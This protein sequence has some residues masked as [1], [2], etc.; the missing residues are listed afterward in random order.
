M[1]YTHLVCNIVHHNDTMC[2]SV[3]TGC[4]CTKPLLSCCIP[5]SSRRK[6]LCEYQGH[7]ECISNIWK[8]ILSLH[9]LHERAQQGQNCRLNVALHETFCRFALLFIECCLRKAVKR[10]WSGQHLPGSGETSVR[11]DTDAKSFRVLTIWSLMVFPSSSMVR[12]LKST[13]IVL[14]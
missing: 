7:M 1:C 9:D 3:I 12:I 14:M 13:P 2:S 6:T 10:G 4:D 8:K 11:Q 5:L